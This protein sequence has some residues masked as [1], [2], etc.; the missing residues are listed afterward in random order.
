[1]TD[2]PILPYHHRTGARMLG[3]AGSTLLT[4]GDVPAEYR[5]GLDDAIDASDSEAEGGDIE[6]ERDVD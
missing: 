6:F 2:S 1:M 4:Y 3:T 5:A